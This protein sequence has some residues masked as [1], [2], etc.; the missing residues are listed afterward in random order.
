M[1]LGTRQP[2]FASIPKY[3]YS[4]GKSVVDLAATCGLVLDP[5]QQD[6][7]M[8]SSGKNADKW[9]AL[10]VG[11][12]VGRQNG[13]NA[14]LEARE[15]A[16]LFLFK[17]KLILHSAHEFKAAKEAFFRIQ[18]L[19]ENNS[20][21]K[22]MLKPKGGIVTSTGNESVNL[23]NG[24][25]L[26]FVA[27]SGG[28]GRG[29]TGD[30]IILD[31]AYALKQEAIGALMPTMSARAITGNPQIWYTSSAPWK[32]S[33]V[34][35]KLCKRGRKGAEPKL[36]YME[37]CVPDKRRLDDDSYAKSPAFW[38]DVADA[39][40]GLG[41]R[42]SEE[43]TLVEK[44]AMSEEMFLRERLG[45]WDAS[46]VELSNIMDMP[47]WRAQE[48]DGIGESPYVISADSKPDGSFSTLAVCER[49]VNAEGEFVPRVEIIDYRPGTQWLIDAIEILI[50]KYDPNAVMIDPSTPIGGLIPDLAK[51]DV[52]DKPNASQT[53]LHCVSTR[54]LTQACAEFL[55]N[56]KRGK[57]RHWPNVILDQSILDAK[58]RFVGDGFA[59]DRKKSDGD[60]SPL[61]AVTLASHG[62]SVHAETSSNLWAVAL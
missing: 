21:L 46:Q 41:I 37:W 33:E 13:K 42:I 6:V 14:I 15:L 38:Q 62:Y 56:V 58:K 26:R 16:G 50:R 36:A 57:M 7:L 52:V 4:V 53:L 20:E 28:S 44:G 51:K 59:F 19:I 43:F 11:L 61:V 60:I 18:Q 27:R 31:E 12:I 40:P 35:L 25:R 2:K 55:D 45:Y 47:T 30:V 8:H 23:K 24:C 54:E 29:F 1:M 17:E 32:E 34:L 9:S 48:Y 10:E 5:W 22:R 49:V 3:D 39:N